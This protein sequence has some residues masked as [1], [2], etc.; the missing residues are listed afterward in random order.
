MRSATDHRIP[1]FRTV[2]KPVLAIAIVVA[3]IVA[4]AGQAAAVARVASPA[5]PSPDTTAI[6]LNKCSSFPNPTMPPSTGTETPAGFPI[7]MPGAVL[8]PA[9][10]APTLSEAYT[11]WND[12]K[13]AFYTHTYQEA[14]PNY[15]YFDCVGFTGY[16]TRM[17]DPLAWQSVTQAVGIKRIGVVPSPLLFE[18]FLNSLKSTPQPGWQSVASVSAIKPGDVLAWQ[19]GSNGVPDTTAVGHSVMPLVAPQ[20]I[21]GSNNTRWEVVIMDSTAGGHGPDDTRKP[22]DPLSQ[23]NAPLLTKSKVVEPSG[24]GIGTIALDTT[25]SGQVTGIEW[26]VGDQPESII[27]GAGTPVAGT[28]PNPIPPFTSAGYDLVAPTGQVTSLGNALNYGP[29][30]AQTL[31]KPVVV[32]APTIDGNGYWESAA[33]GGVFSY[34]TAPFKGSMGGQHVNQPIVGMAGD[35]TGAGYWLVAG[36]GGVFAFGD[37]AFYGSMGSQPLNA[38]IKGMVAT[39]D[40]KGYW[41]VAGDGGVFAFGDA[42]YLGSEGGAHLNQPVAGMTAMPDGLGYWLTASDGGVFAFGHA[43]FDGSMGGTP[44]TAPVVNIATTAD[45]AGYWEFAAD[46]GVFAF[47]DAPYLGRSPAGLATAAGATA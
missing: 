15:F 25:T 11:E 44:L 26:N 3:P 36:D 13:C 17:S 12:M 42:A 27:F 47:G 7:E 32:I 33:D 30:A 34:G 31:N 9:S 37:A 39:P 14:P 16:T 8:A 41:L 46:G 10:A 29:T 5:A 35:S 23:R 6:V 2:I 21:P 24:I 22:N 20:P 28:P 19:P 1:A 4:V 45:G 43:A 18:D 38:T 40:G